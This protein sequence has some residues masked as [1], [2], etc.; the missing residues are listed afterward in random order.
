MVHSNVDRG[1]LMILAA[2]RRRLALEDTIVDCNYGLDFG[3]VAAVAGV[4]VGVDVATR[5]II[6]ACIVLNLRM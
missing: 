1:A 6:L 4:L 3:E 5:D 2:W